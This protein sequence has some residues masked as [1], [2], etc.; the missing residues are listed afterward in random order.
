MA[1]Q[2]GNKVIDV[3]IVE[4]IVSEREHLL[5]RWIVFMDKLD[6]PLGGQPGD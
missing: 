1:L 5:N 4:D 2:R 3:V 6:Q